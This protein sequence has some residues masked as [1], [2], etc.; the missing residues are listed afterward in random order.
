MDLAEPLVTA[1]SVAAGVVVIY[2]YV[3]VLLRVTGN[4]TLSSLRVFDFLVTVAMGTVIGTAAIQAS[5]DNIWRA[6]V[7]VTVL[8]LLQ[9]FVAWLSTRYQVAERV[10]TNAPRVVLYN[11]DYLEDEMRSARV[12]KQEIDL[13]IREQGIV[14]VERVWAVV[15]EAN[16]EMSVLRREARQGID[17]RTTIAS[18][19]LPGRNRGQS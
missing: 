5:F 13:K 9:V 11:G 15:L 19:S 6:G 17:G 10:L 8:V 3:V 2:V 16:G 18:V 7:A 12:T 1:A 14:G 4:R